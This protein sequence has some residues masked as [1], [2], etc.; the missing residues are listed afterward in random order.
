M[1]TL[2]EILRQTGYS[3]DGTLTAQATNSP[4]TAALSEHIKTLPQQ[5]ATNQATLDS[6][7]G[8]WNKT[9]FAT[10]QPN[11]N[12]RPEAIQE[13]TQLMPS[14]GGLT[15]WH[16]TPHKIQGAFDISKV[17]TGEGAQAYGHGMYFAENPAVAKEYANTLGA[18]SMS[19]DG[20]PITEQITNYDV[21]KTCR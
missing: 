20:K 19:I 21:Q 16:G 4:M 13:L 6:A 15:A 2:A 3:Q 7:I 5:L 1:A 9:D 18:K 17:G 12:Y 10:G 14:I 11:P 8:S